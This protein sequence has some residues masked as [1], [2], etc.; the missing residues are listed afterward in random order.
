MAGTLR[1]LLAEFLGTFIW[2]F[3]AAGAI[4]ADAALEGGLGALGVALGQG[5]AM[6]AAFGLFGGSPGMFNPAVTLALAAFRRLEIVKAALCL[7][8]QLLA[9][10]AAG[11]LLSA[12][13]SHAH[14]SSEPPFLG[15]PTLNGMGFRAA[16]L[17]EAVL[18]FFLSVACVASQG[19]SN[20]TRALVVGSLGCAASLV[21]GAFCG[22]AMNP[23]RAFGPAVASGYWSFH[24]VYWAGPLAGAALGVGAANLLPK[25]G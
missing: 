2:V 21:L 19:K 13:F 24:Y 12:A 11:L 4:C 25:E 23:A 10:A 17:L 22:A 5:L 1:S 14:I 3:F 16:T 6:A 9:A 15:V 18:T 8:C 20:P 7:V